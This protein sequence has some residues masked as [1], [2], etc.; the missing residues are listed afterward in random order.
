[1][2][3][4][5]SIRFQDQQVERLG[6]I[7]RRLGKRPSETVALLVEEA[8][9]MSE[10]SH[11]DFRAS[12]AGRQAYVK[13]SGLAVWEVAMVA[14]DY[15][16][17]VEKVAAHL[18]WPRPWVQ[19]AL[20]YARDYRDEIDTALADNDAVDFAALQ[21]LLPQAEQISVDD[22]PSSGEKA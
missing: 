2:S 4:V 9:R 20:Q 19:A 11:I 5:L 12:M 6:R 13:G 18:Q 1:M 21:R 15:G 10:H 3:R 22:N 14:R 17:D 8:L 16:G 7:S